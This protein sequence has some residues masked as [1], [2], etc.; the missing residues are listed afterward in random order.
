MTS[1]SDKIPGTEYSYDFHWRRTLEVVAL[2]SIPAPGN[3]E[4]GRELTEAELAINPTW[5]LS[6]Y[7]RKTVEE[8]RQLRGE[9]NAAKLRQEAILAA[10][11][12][13]DDEGIKTRIDKIA[14]EQAAQQA[15]LVE[16]LRAQ[17]VEAAPALADAVAAQ[18]DGVDVA[19]LRAAVEAGVRSVL[20]SLD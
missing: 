3:A 10:I 5:S 6:T 15:A 8:V 12:G 1:T 11:E 4:D 2:D 13:V 20:G 7:L 14:A 17:I 16:S 18:L 9:A 19:Q